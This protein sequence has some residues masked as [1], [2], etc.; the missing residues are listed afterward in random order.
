MDLQTNPELDRA[1]ELV[2]HTNKSVFLTGKAGSGKTTFLRKIKED[3]LKQL[4]VVAPTGV[5]AINAGGMTIHSMFQL[6]FG[7]HLPVAA[8][9]N[10]QHSH[11]ISKKKIRLMRG[12][13]LL[14]I[15]EISMV[16]ADLLD[17]IDETLRRQRRDS[18]PFGG[19]Q[20]LMIGDLHQLPPVTKDEDWELLRDYYDTPYFFN[21]LALK[22]TDYVS[23]ELKHIYRQSDASFIDLLN[24]VRDNRLDAATLQILNSRYV[25]NFQPKSQEGYITLTAT[26]AVANDINTRNLAQLTSESRTFAAQIKGDFP[27]SAYPTEEM[28]EFKIGAQVM[29]IKNDTESGKRFFNGKIGRIT[30]FTEDSIYVRCRDDST[31]IEVEPTGWENI[32][33]SLNEETK[34]VQEE[35]LGT[36]VQYP[37]KL[38]W[39]ITIHKSQGLTFDR[40]VI[41]AQAAFAHGQVYVALS[42]CT[43]F[44]GIVLR[45]RIVPSSVKTDLVVKNYSEEME[46]NTPS[47]DQIREAKRE[48]QEQLV[49]EL[50]DFHVAQENLQRLGQMY[51]EHQNTLAA[52]ATTSVQMLAER[53]AAELFVIT[54]RFRPQLVDYLRQQAMPESNQ[55]LQERVRKAALYFTEKITGVMQQ[56]R[57][58]PT[59]TDNQAVRENIVA[60]L[61]SLQQALFVKKACFEAC[62]T[63][64]VVQ[65]YQRAKVRAALDFVAQ[66]T[67]AIVRSPSAI[68]KNAPHPQLYRQ[69][70]QY[71]DEMADKNNIAPHDVMPNATVRELVTCLPT[72]KKLLD[73]RGI[74]KARWKRYGRDISEMIAR[75]CRENQLP[76]DQQQR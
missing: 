25:A 76:T 44:E 54:D 43:S 30:G 31:D 42:R 73:I 71:R 50:F 39:A 67:A 6:P 46:H 65:A 72:G 17:A 64:F 55:P 53:A 58:I 21:S 59:T 10:D 1:F 45:S 19:V 69:L 52:D 63:G 16:R 2:R 75:Y 12:L 29:F 13:D 70:L 8:R 37:L 9:R 3:G 23:L 47:E 5:A 57:T 7:V 18:R 4:V 49:A 34:E 27:P 38:A 32:R 33:Y 68:P 60:Q 40:A 26:N 35:V 28:L 62:A 66:P 14:V 11:R 51:V 24:K 48:L 56:A 20:L 15:D 61:V 74:G 36:F 41:D 22:R